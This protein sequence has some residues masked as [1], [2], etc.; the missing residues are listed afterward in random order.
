MKIVVEI[1]PAYN[2]PQ[3]GVAHKIFE[4]ENADSFAVS[5]VSRKPSQYLELDEAVEV[6]NYDVSL[7]SIKSRTGLLA[8]TVG[9]EEK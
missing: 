2:L 6:R 7:E 8:G 3:C 4:I 1:L 5:H 9:G